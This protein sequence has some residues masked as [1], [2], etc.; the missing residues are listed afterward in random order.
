MATD[1]LLFYT[2]CLK[3]ERTDGVVYAFT[4][5]D[6]DLT[7]ASILYSSFSY[8]PSSLQTKS[9][10]AVNNFDIE[11]LI[12]AGA[13][14]LGEIRRGLFD[15]ARLT[16]FMYDWDNAVVVKT[17][18]T[19]FLG[20]V[21][22]VRGRYRAE[23]RSLLQFLQQPIGRKYTIDC[24]AE[25]G[26]SRCGFNA[27]TVTVTGTI[28]G[29]TSNRVF[30]DSGRA[31]ADDYFNYGVITFTSGDNNGLSMEIEAFGAGQFTTFLAMPYD[32]AIGD[33]YSAVSGCDRKLETCR[34]KF[35]NV[36]RQKA[37]SFIPGRD[38]LL[39]IG[40]TDR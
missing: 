33:T 31:E 15:G 38:E 13:V 20:E 3:I 10:L 7:I 25:F 30:S 26:D 14:E 17:L 32:V 1:T 9:N 8:S 28:T 11:G 37:F 40:G 21:K 6:Q 24:D 5:H 34:D 39:R 23:F 16:Y 22:P 36:L 2:T 27:A 12:E 18:L 29:V 19:G 4:E 35:N